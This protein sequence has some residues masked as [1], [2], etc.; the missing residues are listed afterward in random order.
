MMK[1][2]HL[3]QCNYFRLHPLI[4]TGLES[5]LALGVVANQVKAIKKESPH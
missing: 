1:E 2:I 5:I 4:H 3:D